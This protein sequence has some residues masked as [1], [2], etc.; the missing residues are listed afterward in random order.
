MRLFSS[1]TA[2]MFALTAT[3][4]EAA[5]F[6]VG[7]IIGAD[8]D[9]HNLDGCGTTLARSTIYR[10]DDKFTGPYIYRDDLDT[11]IMRIDGKIVE[12]KV[13][14]HGRNPLVPPSR[15]THETFTNPDHTITTDVRVKTTWVAPGESSEF[16][17]LAGTITLTVKGVSQTIPVKGE[18][19]C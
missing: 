12:L 18:G 2:I 19:G 11:A 8:I 9:S 1:A 14:E 6:K 7:D 17:R 10:A 16:W 5:G 4:V 15:M 3:S 13:I